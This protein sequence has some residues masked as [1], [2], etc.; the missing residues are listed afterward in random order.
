[1]AKESTETGARREYFPPRI[2]HTEKIEGRA[3][4]CSMATDAC[5]AGPIQS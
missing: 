3:V 4:N 5:S 1:M 2:V